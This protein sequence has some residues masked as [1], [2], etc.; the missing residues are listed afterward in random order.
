MLQFRDLGS[1]LLNFVSAHNVYSW[2]KNEIISNIFR[3]QL[4]LNDNE[5]NSNTFKNKSNLIVHIDQ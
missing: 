5:M 4:N 3:N 1:L 2:N